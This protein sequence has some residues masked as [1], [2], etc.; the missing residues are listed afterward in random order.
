MLRSAPAMTIPAAGIT[1]SPGWDAAFSRRKLRASKAWFAKLNCICVSKVPEAR[2]D[3]SPLSMAAL[4]ASARLPAGIRGRDA[5]DFR[6]SGRRGRGSAVCRRL[7][8]APAAM[9]PALRTVETRGGTH[10]R[11]DRG[12]R[13]RSRRAD[14]H[15]RADD[16]PS[17][18]G[19]IEATIHSG[20]C[21]G[22]EQPHPHRH[23]G[24]YG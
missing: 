1:D 5:V 3:P 7:T 16:G 2:H 11:V 21:A 12:Y 8:F 18:R 15:A 23:V 9:A 13:P 22:D 19:P 17:G 10:R 6:G 14:V 24:R 4:A 20:G